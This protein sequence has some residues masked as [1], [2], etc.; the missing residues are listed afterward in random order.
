VAKAVQTQIMMTIGAVAPDELD[1]KSLPEALMGKVEGYAR[2][3]EKRGWTGLAQQ[4]RKLT[5]TPAGESGWRV[6]QQAA[7]IVSSFA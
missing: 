6:H 7:E 4:L 2:E 3:Y 1:A 5:S